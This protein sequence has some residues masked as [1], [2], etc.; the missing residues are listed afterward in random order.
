TP[1]D[2]GVTPLLAA[3]YENHIDCARVLLEKSKHSEHF[4]LITLSR[5]LVLEYAVSIVPKL[6][7]DVSVLERSVDE[8]SV[9]QV[10]WLAELALKSYILDM[11][12]LVKLVHAIQSTSAQLAL[13]RA[14]NHFKP[15]L[16]LLEQMDVVSEVVLCHDKERLRSLWSNHFQSPRMFPDAPA[17]RGY[18]GD[19]IGFYFSW[20]QTYC[21]FLLGPTAAALL[22]HIISLMISFINTH[23]CSS[24]EEPVPSAL[25]LLIRLMFTLLMI[26]WALVCTKL[27]SRQHATL[28]ECWSSNPLL[29]DTTNDL[30][31]LFRLLDQ[32]PGYHGLWRESRVTGQM[33]VHFPAWRRRLRYLISSL[34]I[35]CCLLAAGFVHVVLLNLEAPMFALYFTESQA[36]FV[37]A[38]LP[39]SVDVCFV[40]ETRI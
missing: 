5:Q 37:E 11:D 23:L 18:F 36:S 19:S 6:K 35:V 8:L 38:L 24:P 13:L 15:T 29:K 17:L 14:Q 22:C 10:S 30:A 27:W 39:L 3:I 4:L 7:N 33:E 28:I 26:I 25:E 20:M 1:D 32:R 31:W 34:V 2:Y 16:L 21:L 9:G 12:M 40:Y